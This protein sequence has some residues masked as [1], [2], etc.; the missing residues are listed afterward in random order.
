VAWPK[1]QAAKLLGVSRPTLDRWIGLG[2]IHMV[3]DGQRKLVDSEGLAA[4]LVEVEQLR[5]MGQD[6][7]VLSMGLHRLAQ[8]DVDGQARL[9]EMLRPGLEAMER[10]DLVPLVIPDNFGPDD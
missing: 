4:L 9:A 8:Q 1:A 3:T 2:K 5:E 7:H 10:G 6:R